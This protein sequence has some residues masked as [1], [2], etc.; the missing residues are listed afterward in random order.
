MKATQ[1]ATGNAI[2]FIVVHRIID[3]TSPAQH[4]KLPIK[5]IFD[6]DMNGV[7]SEMD[8]EISKY[9]HSKGV[10]DK[11]D[12]TNVPAIEKD[13]ISETLDFDLRIECDDD[14]IAQE[15]LKSV[16]KFVKIKADSSKIPVHIK[17]NAKAN[18]RDFAFEAE[19]KP[20]QKKDGRPSPTLFLNMP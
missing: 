20:G 9:E 6:M 3:L 15:L 17:I 8:W 4:V 18:K 2:R 12:E 13:A 19:I 5:I 10:T 7:S 14:R 1:N 16:L 11:F